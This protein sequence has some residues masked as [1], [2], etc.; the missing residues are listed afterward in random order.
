MG[1]YHMLLTPFSS[2]LCTIV[3]PSGKYEYW[4]LPMGLSRSPDVFQEKMSNLMS[5]VDFARAYLDNLLI[6]STE[7]GFDKHLNKL[8]QV[9]TRLQEAGLKIS[10]V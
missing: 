8:E 9:L 3:L 7:K 5:G 4:R 1:Y 6:L 10:A 2:R